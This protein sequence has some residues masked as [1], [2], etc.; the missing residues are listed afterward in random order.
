MKHPMDLHAILSLTASNRQQ[1]K[2]D[3][4][5]QVEGGIDV[6]SKKD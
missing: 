1:Q 4:K 2:E 6:K 5:T 3:R